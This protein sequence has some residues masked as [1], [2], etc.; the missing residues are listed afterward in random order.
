[1]FLLYR[2][3]TQGMQFIK[4]FMPDL[5]STLLR[6]FGGSVFMLAEYTCGWPWWQASKGPW[7]TLTMGH[8]G[9]W[10]NGDIILWDFEVKA[11]RKLLK[12]TSAVNALAL[13]LVS[14]RWQFYSLEMYWKPQFKETADFCGWWVLTSGCFW[15]ERRARCGW[16]ERTA[17]QLVTWHDGVSGPSRTNRIHGIWLYI[18][19]MTWISWI[20]WMI[21]W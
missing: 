3:Y 11:R 13:N 1:M 15:G 16:Q 5:A 19:Y 6:L 20:S 4:A 14:G 17:L 7:G 2:L 12:M 8:M 21:G 9:R 10:G 18:M